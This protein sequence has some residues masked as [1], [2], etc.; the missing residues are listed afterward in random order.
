MR[1]VTPTLINRRLDSD[2]F[3][4]FEQ[5]LSTW[6]AGAPL[7]YFDQNKFES[8]YDLSEGDD[9]FLMSIDLP[10]LNKDDISLDVTGQTLTISGERKKPESLSKNR[11]QRMERVY[12]TFSKTFTL[13]KTIEA[14]KVEARYA[15]GVLEIFLPK[16]ESSRKRSIQV[17]SGKTGFFDKLLGAKKVGHDGSSQATN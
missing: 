10:G 13:P 1:F 17:Q 4:D 14:E 11:V 15:E 5:I 7:A 3:E 16:H 8:S 6:N 12:G 2:L 9:H